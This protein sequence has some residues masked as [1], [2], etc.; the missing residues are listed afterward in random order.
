MVVAVAVSLVEAVVT[1]VADV[2]VAVSRLSR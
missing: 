1:A 2:V